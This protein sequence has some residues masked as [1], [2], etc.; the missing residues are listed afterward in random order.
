GQGLRGDLRY[1]ITYA[2]NNPGPDTITFAVTGTINLTGPL[3]NL[4]GDLTIAGPGADQLTVQ[5]NSSGTYG[6]FRVIASAT[7]DI[8][9]LTIAN[10]IANQG[11]G[12]YS[13]GTLTLA[14][15][16][17]SGNKA[18]GGLNGDGI[19]GGIYNAGTMRISYS[20]VANNVATS[21]DNFVHSS[22]GGGI[23]NSN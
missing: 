18:D 3:P 2:N 20:T 19:G 16:I 14:Y 1:C 15:S 21:K 4:G 5:R 7:V 17:V 9:G 22:G 11:A 23:V 8:S 6:L 12:I 10:S 13:N